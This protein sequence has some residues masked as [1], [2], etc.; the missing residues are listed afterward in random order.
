[1]QEPISVVKFSPDSMM[2]A[3]G[4]HDNYIDIYKDRNNQTH[5]SFTLI[6]TYTDSPWW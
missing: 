6:S 4:G 3:V 1:M 5:V 2:L